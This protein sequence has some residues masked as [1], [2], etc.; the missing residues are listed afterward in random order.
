M[1]LRWTIIGV[2]ALLGACAAIPV[3]KGGEFSGVSA[4]APGRGVVYFYRTPNF[5][6]QGMTAVFD[7]SNGST[8]LI[9]N[10]GYRRVEL[11][12]GIYSAVLRET[13]DTRFYR[14]P[15][16]Q[17]E[18]EVAAGGVSFV[19]VLVRIE[20]ADPNNPRASIY[21][22]EQTETEALSDDEIWKTAEILTTT[23]PDA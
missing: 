12:P 22:G 14:V 20:N 5:F 4:P 18:F 1:F 6:G 8:L 3:E 19:E 9:G 17:L 21:I 2:C 15:D 7:L 16:I 23:L 10:G 13:S 11:A